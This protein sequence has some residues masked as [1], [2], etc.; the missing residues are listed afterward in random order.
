MLT[1]TIIDNINVIIGNLVFWPVYIWIC[2]LP[3]RMFDMVIK[4]A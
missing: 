2:T 4:N 3:E 1:Q